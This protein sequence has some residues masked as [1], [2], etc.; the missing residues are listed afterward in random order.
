MTGARWVRL[1]CLNGVTDGTRTRVP[2]ATSWCLCRLDDDHHKFKIGAGGGNRTLIFWVEAKHD[3]RY[4]TPA[5]MV[6]LEGFEPSLQC[7]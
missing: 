4:T 1:V 2:S 6:G 3:S 7:P 5:K